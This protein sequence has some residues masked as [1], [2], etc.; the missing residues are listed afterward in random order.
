MTRIR[1]LGI[2]FS[3]PP[4]LLSLFDGVTALLCILPT[5]YSTLHT[6]LYTTW[7]KKALNRSRNSLEK[8]AKTIFHSKV[9]CRKTSLFGWVG[10]KHIFLV[11][12]S[13]F[14]AADKFVSGWREECRLATNGCSTVEERTK[15]TR[16][17]PFLLR[18]KRENFFLLFP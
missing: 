2:F 5:I 15:K 7:Q 13:S 17:V 10:E 9:G 4:S 8:K 16:L 18:Q 14:F 12:S 3:F 11:F 6:V 1:N